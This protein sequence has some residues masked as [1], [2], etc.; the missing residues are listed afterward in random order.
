MRATDIGIFLSCGLFLCGCASS[1]SPI[2]ITLTDLGTASKSEHSMTGLRVMRSVNITGLGPN[3]V[4]G[5]IS[6]DP[7]PPNWLVDF[8]SPFSSKDYPDSLGFRL[9]PTCSKVAEMTFEADV[10][11]EDVTAI[12][13]GLQE[14]AELVT[15]KLRLEIR[16]A[17]FDQALAFLASG[18][19][20][21]E[22][23]T[24]L[25]A[26]QN[27]FPEYTLT[28]EDKIKEARSIVGTT[29]RAVEKEV[30]DKQK[31]LT[32]ALQKPGIVTTRWSVEKKRSATLEAVGAGI[33]AS[34][35]AIQEGFLVL[36]SPRVVT[37]IVGSDAV[38]R[39]RRS[40]PSSDYCK[41]NEKACVVEVKNLITPTRTYMTYYQLSAKH[42]AWGETRS[43]SS[44]VAIQA[45]L[46]KIAST[47][48]PL[49][50]AGSGVPSILEQFQLKAVIAFS[51]VYELGNSGLN[52]GGKTKIFPFRFSNHDNY[53]KSL[54]EQQK[55]ADDYRPIYNARATIDRFVDWK[56]NKTQEVTDANECADA[57][58]ISF[59][60]PEADLPKRD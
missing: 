48:N 55:R 10:R 8:P 60:K 19:S 41:K 2:A 25:K 28:D 3:E 27:T 37:M 53:L 59:D 7:D 44:N 4:V 13:D 31:Q 39:V 18:A 29:Q 21:A 16:V 11:I 38:A 32:A 6:V 35:T 14:L 23:A 17:A 30:D 20:A 50:K 12:R 33:Q 1:V 52:S 36:G 54:V 9:S 5:S 22:N 57:K 49:I 47:L 15:N 24:Y 42:L 51:K 56:L 40:D 34:K 43:G 46:S 45:D 58:N 26:L